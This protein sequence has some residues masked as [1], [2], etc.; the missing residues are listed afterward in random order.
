MN[1]LCLDY[2]NSQWYNSHKSFEEPLRSATWR[3]ELCRKWNL[4][5]FDNSDEILNELIVLRDLLHAA[6]IEFV[7]VKDISD[8]SLKKLNRYLNLTHAS[9][10][11]QR[12]GKQIVLC[13]VADKNSLAWIMSQIVLSFAEMIT[14]YPIERIKMCNNPECDWIFYDESKSK[15]RK[16]CEN[17]CASLIKVR[18]FRAKMSAACS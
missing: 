12:D 14:E 9:K 15:T 13:T 7:T 3:D 5:G 11:L 17:A 16:W 4:P 10:Q 1:F 2:L 18:K 6:A 8:A